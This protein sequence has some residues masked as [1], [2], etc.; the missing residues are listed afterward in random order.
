MGDSVRCGVCTAPVERLDTGGE[1]GVQKVDLTR[2]PTP[3][4]LS[5]QLPDLTLEQ[6]KAQFGGSV[7]AAIRRTDATYKEFGDPA[8]VGRVIGGDI[9]AV[10]A[11]VWARADTRREFLLAMADASG[12][13]E[14]QTTITLTERRRAS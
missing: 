9:S 10:L 1:G 4:M 7:G 12:L 13:F 6:A 2:V 8:L 14:V 3:K 11:R 5:A